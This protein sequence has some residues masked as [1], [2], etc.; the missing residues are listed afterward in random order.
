[1]KKSTALVFG[2][3]CGLLVIVFKLIIVLGGFAITNFGFKWSQ[4]ISVLLVLPFIWLAIR[5][6]RIQNGGFIGGKEALR[7]GLQTAILA[8]LIISVYHYIELEWKWKDIAA[9]YYNSET[10]LNILK[11]HADVKQ[12]QYAK[13]INDQIQNIQ[14]LSP[15]KYVTF[16][17][18][19]FLLFSV[20]TAFMCAVFMKK[21]PPPSYT[22]N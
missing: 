22:N 3:I 20:T 12:E 9:V 11:S 6:S 21:S 13:I 8:I 18:V 7:T 10:F 1:M 17:M 14:T 15:F 19:P 4:I 5:Q 2:L 16:K